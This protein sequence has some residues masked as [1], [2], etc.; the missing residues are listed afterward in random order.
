M[1]IILPRLYWIVYFHTYVQAGD[2]LW[3]PYNVCLV[4]V[5]GKIGGTWYEYQ[6]VPA[7]LKAIPFSP[8]NW[9]QKIIL[10]LDLSWTWQSFGAGVVS[11]Y[12]P[13]A[14]LEFHVLDFFR[15]RLLQFI[16]YSSSLSIPA[17]DPAEICACELLLLTVPPSCP[18]FLQ[19]QVLQD[20]LWHY[21]ERPKNWFGFLYIF[22]SVRVQWQH[23]ALTCRIAQ[24]SISV[25]LLKQQFPLNQTTEWSHLAAN[26]GLYPPVMFK[27]QSLHAS[28]LVSLCCSA[29]DSCWGETQC[30]QLQGD[31]SQMATG[32]TLTFIRPLGKS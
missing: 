23:Q 28:T 24:E 16:N 32:H 1:A 3:F 10:L 5:L 31:G 9:K 4:L 21:S 18:L 15:P 13:P 25:F 6:N 14:S 17:L 27:G 20:A 26:A 8:E 2:H 22:F 29:G 30:T 12:R 19:C 7:W 11:T